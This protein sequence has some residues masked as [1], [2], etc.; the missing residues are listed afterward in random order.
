MNDALREI[1]HKFRTSSTAPYSQ[2]HWD[3]VPIW[4]KAVLGERCEVAYND[5][6]ISNGT[7]R[8]LSH[9]MGVD[10][11]DGD[12]VIR[13]RAETRIGSNGKLD[14]Q[15]S[16]LAAVDALA[17][18]LTDVSM[19]LGPN[20]ETLDAMYVPAPKFDNC[21]QYAL[22]YAAHLPQGRLLIVS[23]NVL[24]EISGGTSSAVLEPLARK[25][26]SHT[27]VERPASLHIPNI[28]QCS[29]QIP[30]GKTASSEGTVTGVGSTLVVKCAVDDL[31]R[32]ASAEVAGNGLLFS[33]CS[34]E[35]NETD[36]AST[37]AFTFVTRALGTHDVDLRFEQALTMTTTSK[38]IQV[39]VVAK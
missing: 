37:V 31:I 18:T 34:V 5:T 20:Y 28:T 1:L 3:D 19:H 27:T 36:K 23:G 8:T 25:L 7:V 2:I 29:C 22:Q 17:S 4:I 35:A 12:V 14:F 6:H 33:K 9:L 13:A 39:T 30:E 26:L 15:Q 16:C 38:R 21:A 11:V 32:A 10:G 24:I